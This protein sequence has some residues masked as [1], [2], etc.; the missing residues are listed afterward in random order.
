M[1]GLTVGQQFHYSFRVEDVEKAQ[2]FVK[3]LNEMFYS[4]G[5][6]QSEFRTKNGV[7]V[8]ACEF[9][10]RRDTDGYVDYLEA[11]KEDADYFGDEPLNYNEWVEAGKPD[12]PYDDDE[13]EE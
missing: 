13:E 7:L 9:G 4:L 11:L 12:V 1:T 6:Q 8:F 3:T 2:E 10:E 5:Q